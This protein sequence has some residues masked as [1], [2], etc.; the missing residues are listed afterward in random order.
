M[1]G[2]LSL[3]PRQ[4]STFKFRCL[5]DFCEMESLFSKS[6]VLLDVEPAVGSGIPVAGKELRH[7]SSRP[8]VL[9]WWP[10]GYMA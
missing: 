5:C 9:E 8:E 4:C 7:S 1:V 6:N 2:R 10:K 3:S